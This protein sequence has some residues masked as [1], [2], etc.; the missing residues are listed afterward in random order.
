MMKTKLEN[1]IIALTVKN[2][3]KFI[4]PEDFSVFIT[5]RNKYLY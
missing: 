4:E 3:S 5:G 2:L 1:C